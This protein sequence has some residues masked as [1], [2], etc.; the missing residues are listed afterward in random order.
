MYGPSVP[1]EVAILAPTPAKAAE[2]LQAKTGIEESFGNARVERQEIWS[3]FVIGQ[4]RIKVR[5][6][7]G[8]R[9]PMDGLLQEQLAFV[10]DVVPI[11]YMNWTRRSQN[12]EPYGYIRICVPDSQVGR[13]PSRLHVFGEAVSVQRIR[14]CQQILVCSRFHGFQATHTCARTTTRQN[15]GADAHLGNCEKSF[16]CLNCRGPHSSTDISCPARP[17]RMNGV[18]VRPTGAQLKHSRM[19]GKREFIKAN[20]Q[21]TANPSPTPSANSRAEST[22]PQI[23]YV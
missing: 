12:D 18:F 6:L 23:K 16:M 22:T 11:R 13:S 1:S 10:R 4:I 17:R 20:N 19:A 3:T 21:T 15:C 9:D 14:K 8:L 7:D 5:Y 2:I